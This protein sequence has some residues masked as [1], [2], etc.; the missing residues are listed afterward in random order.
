MLGELDAELK[1]WRIPSNP[2]ACFRVDSVF[3][4]TLTTKFD[5]LDADVLQN[6]SGAVT[7]TKESQTTELS[8]VRGVTGYDTESTSFSDLKMIIGFGPCSN[9]RYLAM[10]IRTPKEQ[11]VE[12]NTISLDFGE[13]RANAQWV[14]LP[15]MKTSA[16]GYIYQGTLTFTKIDF[17]KTGTVE[18]AFDAPLYSLAD[19]DG[20]A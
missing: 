11:F 14:E 20:P 12:G 3:S 5:T 2:P 7:E 9:G 19:R 15:S 16:A 4:G 10:E 8:L 1:D 17:D 13:A 18:V 6:G